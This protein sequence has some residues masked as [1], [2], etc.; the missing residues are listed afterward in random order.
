MEIDE[1]EIR[2]LGI[3]TYLTK[4]ALQWLVF[5]FFLV[6]TK[7]FKNSKIWQS[8]EFQWDLLL[9]ALSWPGCL[10]PSAQQAAETHSP[11]TCRSPSRAGQGYSRGLCRGC[12]RSREWGVMHGRAVLAPG[13]AESF[14]SL[15]LPPSGRP[16]WAAHPGPSCGLSPAQ[17]SSK[18]AGSSGLWSLAA[19]YL[20][21]FFACGMCFMVF[22]VEKLEMVHGSKGRKATCSWCEGFWKDKYWFCWWLTYR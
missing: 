10:D 17:L 5:F 6:L 2:N 11:L 20:V 9:L 7:I 1:T 13:T 14:P 4:S 18:T 16:R 21:P 22:A 15:S 19:P 12:E 3:L 8:N